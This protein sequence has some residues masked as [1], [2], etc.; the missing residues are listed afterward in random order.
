M[1]TPPF[2]ITGY[3]ISKLSEV[4]SISVRLLEIK[5]DG[6]CKLV[7]QESRLALLNIILT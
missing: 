1:N 2:Q 6:Y 3:L 5:K 7:I 4:N